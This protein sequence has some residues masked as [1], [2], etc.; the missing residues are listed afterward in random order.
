MFSKILVKVTNFLFK[1]LDK[2]LWKGKILKVGF[3]PPP[4]KQKN[5]SSPSPPYGLCF[6]LFTT[7][8]QNS[9]V[10]MWMVKPMQGLEKRKIS[11]AIPN[12]HYG[13]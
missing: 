4:P 5:T 7:H 1:M 3:P 13:K 12:C 6:Y 2:H 11:K 9:D 10:C 8:F